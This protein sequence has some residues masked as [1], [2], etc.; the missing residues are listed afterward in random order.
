M[1]LYDVFLVHKEQNPFRPIHFDQMTR[2][3]FRGVK[4]DSEEAVREFWKDF[5]V[6]N[7]RFKNH[8]IAE[9]KQID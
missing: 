8:R 9:I 3:V 5:K 7:D 2:E 1:P 4:A 6:G